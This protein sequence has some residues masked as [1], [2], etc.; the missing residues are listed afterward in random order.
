MN[1]DEKLKKLEEDVNSIFD[2]RDEEIDRQAEI[3]KLKNLKKEIKISEDMR[4][5]VARTFPN[6]MDDE[7]EIPEIENTKE[8]AKQKTLGSMKPKNKFQSNGF[9]EGFIFTLLIGF[10]SGTIFTIAYILLKAGKYT[11]IM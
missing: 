3:D 4:D 8:K 9:A 6:Q 2:N 5:M 10:A 1:N 11:F 7:I